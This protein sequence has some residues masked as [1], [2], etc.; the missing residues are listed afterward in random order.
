MKGLEYT[1][2]LSTD[3]VRVAHH[4]AHI[5]EQKGEGFIVAR[6]QEAG[7]Y[8]A[9]AV[10]VL[11]WR[12]FPLLR[13]LETIRAAARSFNVQVRRGDLGPAPLD[14]ILEVAREVLLLDRPPV[15]TGPDPGERPG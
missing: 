7:P 9:V 6:G 3:D 14:A 15:I 12:M 2:Y 11:D 10:N 5:L 8:T 4:L 13:V 1:L